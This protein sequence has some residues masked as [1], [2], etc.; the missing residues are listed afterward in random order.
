MN[1]ADTFKTL[2]LAAWRVLKEA[3]E[4]KRKI[5]TIK[6]KGERKPSTGVQVKVREKRRL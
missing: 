5:G 1:D 2:G 4:K 3:A 6:D